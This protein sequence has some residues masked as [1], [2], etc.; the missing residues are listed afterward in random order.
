MEPETVIETVSLGVSAVAQVIGHGGWKRLV[1][2]STNQG[3]AWIDEAGAR[4]LADLTAR[5][6]PASVAA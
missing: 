6:F 1:I 2:L 3:G 5:H 4:A